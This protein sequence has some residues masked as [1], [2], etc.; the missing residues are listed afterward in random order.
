MNG[1]SP[2]PINPLATHEIYS[3]GNMESIVETIPIDISRTPII[4]ENVF[5]EADYSP[6][7]IQTYT[8]L[9]KEFRDVFS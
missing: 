8:K 5:V 4:M 3:K 6:K 2:C 1:N 7:D 9:S